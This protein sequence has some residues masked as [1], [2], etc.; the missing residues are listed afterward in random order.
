[1]LKYDELELACVC[2]PMIVTQRQ[3]RGN[4]EASFVVPVEQGSV[5]EKVRS[6]GEPT[7]CV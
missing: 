5:G 3:R 4:A 2:Y 6:K 7:F 1:M